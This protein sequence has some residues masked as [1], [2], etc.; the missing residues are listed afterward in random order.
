MVSVAKARAAMGPQPVLLGNLHPVHVVKNG[1][2]EDVWNA[3][4]ACHRA[5]GPRYIAG[6]GCE[7]PRGSPAV[8]VRTFAE[9]ARAGRA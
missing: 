1:T 2:R 3:L 6:A 7:I 9:Y 8:N 4:A 5:A